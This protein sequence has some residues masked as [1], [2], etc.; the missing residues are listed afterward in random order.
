MS[1]ATARVIAKP[2]G[3][4]GAKGSP[5]WQKSTAY[6]VR[7]MCSTCGKE[8]LGWASDSD[9]RY[10]WGF[11]PRVSGPRKEW[12]GYVDATGRACVH[13]LTV[14]RDGCFETREEALLA[15]DAELA[16]QQDAITRQRE[17]VAAMLRGEEAQP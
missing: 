13:R 3:W 12:K 11:C 4:K 6:G 16:A 1:S 9:R 7:S 17:Q 14:E 8:V 15:L 2:S 5:Y 10:H